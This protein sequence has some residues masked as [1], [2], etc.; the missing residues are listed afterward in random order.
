[1]G[2]RRKGTG[3]VFT[4]NVVIRKGNDIVQSGSVGAQSA[5]RACAVGVFVVVDVPRV[6][7]S[8]R[9]TIGFQHRWYCV[10]RCLPTY[11]ASGC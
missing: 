10:A 7:R 5:S 6:R 11:H 1:M 8:K 4:P 2:V 3:V 9:M